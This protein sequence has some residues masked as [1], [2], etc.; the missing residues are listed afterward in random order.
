MFSRFIVFDTETPNW[1]NDRMCSIGLCIVE[2][3]K[4]VDEYY[5]LIDPECDYSAFNIGIHGITPEMTAQ[6]PTFPQVWEQIRPIF[7]SG[8][9]VAHNAQFDMSVLS[10]CLRAYAIP[11]KR[12]TH[13][14]CTCQMGRTALPKAPNHK[15][16]TLCSYLHIPLDHHNAASDS[17]ACSQLLINY[18]NGG[19][20]VERYLRTYDIYRICTLRSKGA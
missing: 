6:S 16:D 10:K 9:P 14:A 7:D 17:R 5:S 15:L 2:G 19:L 4:I 18:I 1:H 20:L 13:Y 3:D 8:I 11:W 12:Y